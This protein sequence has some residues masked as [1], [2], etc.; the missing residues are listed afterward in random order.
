MASAHR[1]VSKSDDM[2]EPLPLTV[3]RSAV[4]MGPSGR[5][6]RCTNT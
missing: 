4:T 6:I 5:P 1:A 2:E 3:G